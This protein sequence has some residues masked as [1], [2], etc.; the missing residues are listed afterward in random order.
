LKPI[1][2]DNHILILNKPAGI[3]TEPHFRDEAR[4]WVK[5]RFNKPGNAFLE[6]IHRLDR[7]VSGIV[8]FARTSKALTRLNEAMR[9]RKMSKTYV[10]IVEGIVP[11][12]GVLEHYLVHGD[13]KAYIDPTGKKAVLRYRRLKV[14]GDRSL[15]EID[16]E[17]GRY[18]QIRAQFA[19][20]GHPILGDRKYGSAKDYTQLPLHHKKLVLEHPITKEM[21]KFQCSAAFSL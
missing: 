3:S 2:C 15:V 12:E 8:L 17:T 13:F 14:E 19:A 5:E 20:I 1:Y 4:V 18:H 6:P 11:E 21:L 9:D 10:A 7:P 16:L